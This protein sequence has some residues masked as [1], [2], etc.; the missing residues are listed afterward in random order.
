MK[1]VNWG[2]IGCGDVT[3]KKSGP[4]LQKIEHSNLVAVMRRQGDKAKDY[5][6]RHGVPKWYGVAA[7][8]IN[9]PEVNAI[10][11]ATPPDSHLLYTVMAAEAGKPIYVEKP[12]GRN[13]KE[14]EKMNKVCAKANVPLYVAY[15]RRALEKFLKVE[16]LLKSNAIGEVRFVNIQHYI[17][18]VPALKNKSDL[19][20]RVQPEI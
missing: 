4:A 1:T 12:M 14:C 16:E 5:A 13:Y 11:I 20:W 6:D 15:Y 17:P 7:D 9:D 10:Y 8:L 18:I 3:E 19:P 2:I